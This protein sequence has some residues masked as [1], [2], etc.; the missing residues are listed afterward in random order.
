MFVKARFADIAEEK[1]DV[2]TKMPAL[3]EDLE[4][5]IIE[6]YRE[7]QPFDKACFSWFCLSYCFS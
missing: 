1:S 5:S 7:A 6:D 4:S 2:Q 3:R